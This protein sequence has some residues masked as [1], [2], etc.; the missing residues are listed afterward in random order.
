MARRPPQRRPL[1]PDSK[2]EHARR[3]T[4]QGPP[5]RRPAPRRARRRPRRHRRLPR[6]CAE[7]ARSARDRHPAARPRPGPDPAADAD[8]DAAPAEPEPRPDQTADQPGGDSSAQTDRPAPNPSE[9]AAD[10]SEAE[11]LPDLGPLRAATQPAQPDL[12]PL[13]AAEPGGEYDVLVEFTQEGAGVE[14]VTLADHAQVL[15]SDQRYGVQRKTT[16]QTPGGQAFTV[17]A[18]AAR[19]VRINGDFVDL[20]G[21]ADTPLWRQTAPGA[22][23][24][25]VETESGDPVARITKRFAIQP[26]SYD[27]RV[28]QRLEN[29][30]G[31]PL[32]Y[33]WIQYGPVDL[34]EDESSYL[35]DPRRVW[36]G[37]LLPAE[38]DP[39]R[40]FVERT[41]IRSRADAIDNPYDEA[42]RLWPPPNA[43]PGAEELVFTSLSNRYFTFAVHAP[44]TP[45]QAESDAPFDKTFEGAERVY[46]VLLSGSLDGTP[47][48]ARRM[49]LEL[50]GPE[51]R[52]GPGQT[53][54]LSLAAYAG[55]LSRK[56]L[57]AEPIYEALG[58][59]QLI[60]YNIGGPCAFCTF[61]PLARGLLYFLSVFHDYIVF[62]WALAIM[63]LVVFVRGVLHPITK[64]SQIRMQRF[65]KQMQNLAPKQKKLQEK[66]KDDPKRLQQEMANL[67]REEGIDFTG[68]LG[69]LPMFLQ[70]PV[71]IALYAML[72]FTF[73]LRHEAAY[74]SVFQALSGGSWSFLA[75]LSAPDRF[76]DFGS[77]LFTVPLLGEISS[78]NILP[79]L[80]GIVFFIQQ[81]YLTP[82]PSTSLSPEQETQQKIMKVLLV[83]MFPLFMYQAPSGLTIYFITNST[84][85][86]FE[87]RYIRAHIAK[88]PEPEPKKKK[89]RPGPKAGPGQAAQRPRKRV[90]NESSTGFKQRKK[91][92]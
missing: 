18:L 7:P 87:S 72:F 59:D 49:V 58:L 78:I 91:K 71:W 16:L 50:H 30:S 33:Q 62:D 14:A 22:F 20:F 5:P 66:Y 27:I 56:T 55:P 79:L 42:G 21:A 76:I 28:E 44:V 24:A 75:D 9:A 92:R 70:T 60:V 36:F 52:L 10:Q 80:L 31:Q 23:E 88:L 86:I 68:A 53:A 84:L 4:Q 77:V 17:A 43:E 32:D 69:C 82:P 1:T 74:F 6:Q 51:R 89:P 15:G 12:A 85:G 35:R 8:R 45:E 26:G 83:V 64:K 57:G 61:Q 67:M 39:S 34:P 11:L 81:K 25:R 29:L 40:Q 37:H 41:D 46:R 63:V 90:L 47:A 38:R 19:G 54:D 3:R 13:G 65:S 2:A 48:A 73:D